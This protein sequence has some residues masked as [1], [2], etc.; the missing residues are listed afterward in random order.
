MAALR[1]RGYGV[2]G[3]MG[4]RSLC[5]GKTATYTSPLKASFRPLTKRCVTY[6]ECFPLRFHVF[7]TFVLLEVFFSLRASLLVSF[8]VVC[9]CLVC[10]CQW[11]QSLDNAVGIA[12]H[13][14]GVI[15]NVNRHRHATILHDISLTRERAVTV[16]ASIDTCSVR[17]DVGPGKSSP[18]LI[19]D[20]FIHISIAS[21]ASLKDVW[22]CVVWRHC[23]NIDGQAVAKRQKRCAF[24]TRLDDLLNNFD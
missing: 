1:L 5:C 23:W 3:V 10:L 20:S 24:G 17:P 15:D 14:R 19:P 2:H 6:A 12:R 21:H 11:L 22:I 9:L 13:G 4:H 7:A 16:D 8:T 18:F